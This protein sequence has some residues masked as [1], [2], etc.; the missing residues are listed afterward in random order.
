MIAKLLS[1]D[2]TLFG[3][4]R[5][6]LAALQCLQEGRFLAVKPRYKDFCRP[7]LR[8]QIASRLDGSEYGTVSVT[9]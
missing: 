7:L 6:I 2:L 3:P 4:F 9:H 8:W 5:L 1:I